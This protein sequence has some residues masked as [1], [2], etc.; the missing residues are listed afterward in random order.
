M[1]RTCQWD[2]SCRRRTSTNTRLRAQDTRT[3]RRCLPG[4]DR[5]VACTQR[6]RF[7]DPHDPRGRTTALLPLPP[8]PGGMGG[9]QGE[10]SSAAL[11]VANL[12][13]KLAIRRPSNLRPTRFRRRRE[14]QDQNGRLQGTEQ[15]HCQGPLFPPAHHPGVLGNEKTDK[16]AKAA[17]EGGRPRQRGPR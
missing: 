14:T 13:V 16:Y 7:H 3:M 10:D 17:A 11:Q 15:D 9:L 6:R 1:A 4:A 2:R 5:L 12:E 8:D